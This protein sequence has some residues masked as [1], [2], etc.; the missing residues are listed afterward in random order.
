MAVNPNWP[1][2]EYGWNEL[3][4][5][6]SGAI[7][8][9]R[10]VNVQDR[11]LGSVA[12]QRGRQ[13]ELDQV[14]SGTLSATLSN[15]DG[16]L[17]PTN[18]SG[19][20]Y[21]HIAP[22][23]PLRVRMQYPSTVNLLTQGQATGGDVGGYVAGTIPASLNIFSSIDSTGG[24]IVASGTAYQGGSVFQFN[25]PSGH[26][27]GSLCWT[28]LMAGLAGTQYTMQMQVR[29]VTA[30]TSQQVKPRI[31]WYD[32]L[33]NVTNS[34]GATATLT[35]STTAPWTQITVT[36]TM[37]ANSAAMSVGVSTAAVPSATASIQV[38]GWQ[39]E[40]GATATAFVVPG[41]WYPFY[42][43]FIER[44][45]SS[46]SQGG[47]YG[48]VQP[49]A[50][51]AFA[52]LSQR[53]L[54]DP[55]TEEIYS[56][57]PRFLYTLGDP[58]GVSSFADAT[59]QHPPAPIDVC[60]Y[61][62]GSLVSGTQITATDPVNGIFTGASGTV[63]TVSN[64]NPG[65]QYINGST[66]I[67][68]GDAG[69]TGPANSTGIWTRMLAFRYTGPMP[70]TA[71]AATIWSC[72]DGTRIND[73][74]AGSRLT[75]FIGADGNLNI[76]IAGT[77][78]SQTILPF[79]GGGNVVDGNWH[80]ALFGYNNTTAQILASLDGNVVA[81]YGSISASS[82]P[83]N[84]ISD[85]VGALIDV[86]AGNGGTQN[87]KG[88]VA[89]LCEW[90]TWLDNPSITAVYSAWKNSF[91]GDTTDT[92]YGRILGWAGY[93]GAT[94]VQ[95]GVTRSMGPATGGS[96][97]MSALQSVVETENGIHFVARDGTLTFNSRGA[98]YNS[99][100]PL[101]IFGERAD[102]GEYA[103]EE[104][105]LDYDPTHLAN[106]VQVTQSSTSQVFTAADKASQTAYFPRNMTRTL[107]ASSGLECQDAA[108]YL[109]SRYKQPVTRITSLKLHP[110]AN[111]S[112]WPVCLSLELG[113]RIR[114][115]RRP[116]GAPAIQLDAFVEHLAWDV[117]DEN[118]AFLTLQCS[119]VDPTPYGLFSAFHTALNVGA[120]SGTN[121][122]TLKNGQDN[123]NP[124]AAQIG[125][126]QQLVIEPGTA[127]A[128]TVTVSA[129]GATS[130]GWTTGALTLS[131]NLTKTHAANAVV[132]GVLPTG[133][134]D[135]TTW[136]GVSALDSIAFSY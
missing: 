80:L 60:K 33:G 5:A 47:T 20:W 119:P 99:T 54:R 2:P 98:R 14:Q 55:L 22:Y 64:T 36:F 71:S 70:A 44:W 134:T 43:G 4:N 18:T 112:L 133:V 130:S 93:T 58:Q 62:P 1:V 107:N 39:L 95:A 35:G 109:L 59:G 56:R 57:S 108:N 9:D 92:R 88:D 124:L 52:L 63:V 11:T 122:L 53:Q 67:S 85:N 72:F 136:D 113:T 65:T 13:Y 83:V 74:P 76:C 19:P 42:A 3:G 50:V 86:T 79:N 128:E 40:T 84:L 129:V 127:N 6:G 30:G 89:F 41:V 123:T 118:D 28:K 31:S 126:N 131:A 101:Y 87:Y 48:V 26:A 24:S 27:T 81:H 94:S 23:Q 75:I 29:N 91:V 110:G 97:A 111:A 37:P 106:L 135:P 73:S 46:W 132:S 100:T 25:S 34:Y 96:D 12:V 38:D 82:A 77:S 8:P 103:Y 15:K 51:D 68:L 7:P 105:T 49:T 116:F 115:M 69:I 10:Y 32:S 102:L 61:G 120:N 21:G 78:G 17:D 104:L 90:P 114:V 66:Y 125:V 117:N 121:T 16:A 45:P